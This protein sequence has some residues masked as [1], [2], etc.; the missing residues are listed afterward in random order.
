MA[1]ESIFPN[2]GNFYC[3]QIHLIIY[4]RHIKATKVF[5]RQK[6][7]GGVFNVGIENKSTVN[8]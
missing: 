2:R 8:N 1:R 7:G 3:K 6:I 4:R 5:R